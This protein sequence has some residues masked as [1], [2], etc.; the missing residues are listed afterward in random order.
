MF[1]FSVG[2]FRMG[3]MRA[4]FIAGGNVVDYM[5]VL[6]ISLMSETR[7]VIIYFRRHVGR[8]VMG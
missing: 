1:L 6:T 4:F 5:D 8:G 2:F 3:V 7:G